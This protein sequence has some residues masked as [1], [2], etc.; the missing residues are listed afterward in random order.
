MNK[1]K[2]NRYVFLWY[3]VPILIL[4]IVAT[5]PKFS[6]G[7]KLIDKFPKISK[8]EYPEEKEAPKESS[9]EEETESSE[10]TSRI[11]VYPNA[12]KAALEEGSNVTE[13]TFYTTKDPIDKVC[14]WY[15]K[16]LK[17]EENQLMMVDFSKE[18]TRTITITMRD[19]PK[20]LVELKYPFMGLDETG[21]TITTFKFYTS[22]QPRW[23][24]PP[25]ESAEE[26]PSTD[27][28]TGTQ[29]S[30]GTDTE[31]NT[32]SSKTEERKSGDD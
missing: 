5:I 14:K 6:F 10:I 28:N 12:E 31:E 4:V 15:D 7:K 30:T 16:Q 11:P 8:Y 20:E 9:S 23:M 18:G 21:I 26:T 27:S 3:L 22:T 19:E 2:S 1:S 24:N 29:E 13:A 25:S 32:D 17:I